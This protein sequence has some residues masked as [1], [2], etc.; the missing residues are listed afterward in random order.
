M[1]K[2]MEDEDFMIFCKNSSFLRRKFRISKAQLAK[3]AHM[4]VSTIT[5]TESGEIP[6]RLKI[7]LVFRL[8][9]C[10]NVKIYELFEPMYPAEE[11]A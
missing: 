8:A 10:F 2:Q 5:K 7:R 9:Q 3:T 6:P 1:Q 11:E 4:A